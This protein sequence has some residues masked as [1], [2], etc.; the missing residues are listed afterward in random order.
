MNA[1]RTILITDKNAALI[2][3]L[4]RLFHSM[5]WQILTTTHFPQGVDQIQQHTV[6]LVIAGLQ[7]AEES[8]GIAFLEQVKA[9]SPGA[10]RLLLAD[11]V[12]DPKVIR[13]LAE[14]L[15]HEVIPIPWNG[16]E[17]R[18]ILLRAFQGR[19]VAQEKGGLQPLLDKI[20]PLPVQP[21]IYQK[22]RREL[23]KR[24]EASTDRIAE[25]I[26]QDPAMTAEILRVANAAV[27]G[28]R[29]RVDTANRAV[30]VLGL[31]LAAHLIFFFSVYQAIQPQLP[32]FSYEA[33]WAH[34]LG[35]GLA[36]SCIQAQSARD[37]RVVER[38][39]VG[40]LLHDLGKLVFACF[41]PRAYTRVLAIAREQ[42]ASLISVETEQLG[43]SHV[44]LGSHLAEQWH[45]P[46]PVVAAIRWHH[47]PA[48]G[49]Q[50]RPL[51]TLVQLADEMVR[52]LGVGFSGNFQEPDLEQ[53][54]RQHPQ[55]RA[56]DMD[57]AHDELVSYQSTGKFLLTWR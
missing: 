46:P 45:L 51:A 25:L 2:A 27:F 36:A 56:S 42:K 29:Q 49:G 33:F 4:R 21:H 26:S 32:E 30:V 16:Q 18:E 35:V 12:G 7:D 10:I 57:R 52:D 24:E 22:V 44:E 5:K 38:A 54:A 17:L 41:L 11:D 14:G 28:Q 48:S 6:N 43:V 8:N 40:G 19:T 31:D 50:Y 23:Q 47:D 39:M 13:G 37:S 34:S 1:T 9:R 55:I 20:G 3:S 15:F 53:Y